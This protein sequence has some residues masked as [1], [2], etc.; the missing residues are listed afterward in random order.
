MIRRA[1]LL[2]ALAPAC[3]S[4][5]TT[6]GEAMRWYE[7][8]SVVD[9][10]TFEMPGGV[11][12]AGV[13]EPEHCRRC[14]VLVVVPGGAQNENLMVEGLRAWGEDMKRSNWRVFSPIARNRDEL[15]YEHGAKD[16][17][18]F[19]ETIRSTKADGQPVGLLGVSNGGIAALQAGARHPHWYSQVVVAPGY[20]SS[21]ELEGLERT[22]AT[23]FVGALD[24]WAP[25]SRHTADTLRARGGRVEHHELP[26]VGHGLFDA[27]S[28]ADVE[29]RALD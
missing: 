11:M 17:D 20:A 13:I 24:S 5:E 6:S 9:I 29:R 23:F 10:R 7:R 18:A 16:L 12:R 14:P 8:P 26:G 3:A 21:S 15:F 1:L 25:L 27:L 4:S 28:W 2:V 22:A 19:V